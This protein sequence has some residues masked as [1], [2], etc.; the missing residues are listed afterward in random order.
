VGVAWAANAGKGWRSR[1]PPPPLSTSSWSQALRPMA[2]WKV[3]RPR[4][5]SSPSDFV[6]PLSGLIGL[7]SG[8][9]GIVLVVVL[10]RF[11]DGSWEIWGSHLSADMLESKW[12]HLTV[13]LPYEQHPL[14]FHILKEYKFSLNICWILLGGRLLLFG[15]WHHRLRTLILLPINGH[16]FEVKSF[17]AFPNI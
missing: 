16:E 9:W 3:S 5:A 13:I 12:I 8:P 2:R 17:F 6:D 10:P 1:P 14:I 15:P 11:G 4:W 7:G